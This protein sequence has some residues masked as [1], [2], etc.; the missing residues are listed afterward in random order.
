MSLTCSNE[1]GNNQM[2]VFG[3]G[4]D[5]SERRCEGVDRMG[6]A[7]MD[8][9]LECRKIKDYSTVTLVGHQWMM[10][11]NNQPKVGVHG[12]EEDGEGIPMW[13]S[14]RGFGCAMVREAAAVL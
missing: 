7:G 5:S 6:G 1:E 13:G 2:E 8:N 9:R 11:R 3:R 10:G 4:E 12:G 14:V